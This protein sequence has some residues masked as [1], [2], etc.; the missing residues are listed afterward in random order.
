MARVTPQEF[1]DKWA[2]R[3]QAASQDYTRGIQRVTQAPGAK[4]AASRA[5]W[6]ARV[7]ESGDK[8]ARKVGAVDL[9]TWQNLAMTKGAQ[10]LATGVQAAKP[11]MQAAAQQ[12]LST[13][14]SVSARVQAMPKQTLQQRIARANAMMQGMHDAYAGAGR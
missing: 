12:L 13:V 11:K 1:A 3:T 8:W 7:A 14:D 9:G 10:N 5:L 2:T 4:A 6:Q